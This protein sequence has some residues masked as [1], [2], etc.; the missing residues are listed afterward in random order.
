MGETRKRWFRTYALGKLDEARAILAD[1]DAMVQA[2]DSSGGC[3]APIKKQ[4]K[5]ALEDV[6]K[7]AR[8]IKAVPITQ[9]EKLKAQAEKLRA[10]RG[11]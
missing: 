3:P 9:E 7:R 5:A 4:V 8:T 2:P 10:K 11:E 1:L 6:E